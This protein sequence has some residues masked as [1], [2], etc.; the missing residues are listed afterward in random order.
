MDVRRHWQARPVAGIPRIN[1]IDSK[2]QSY[3]ISQSNANDQKRNVIAHVISKT[4]GVCY[5]YRF[6]HTS[7]FFSS[8][9][10]TLSSFVVVVA[11]VVGSPT[12]GFF[13][14]SCVVEEEEAV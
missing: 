13:S 9:V 8:S 5:V 2:K 10:G 7:N 6:D 3:M 12:A 4:L 11:A 14:V 1:H